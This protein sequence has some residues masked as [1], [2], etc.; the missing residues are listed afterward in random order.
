MPCGHLGADNQQVMRCLPLA[1]R[2]LSM[3]E[4]VGVDGLALGEKCS[5]RG[6]MIDPKV[7]PPSW[8][9]GI[10]KGG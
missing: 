5:R 7:V 4:D 10:G 8:G 3:S 9:S 6:V 1:L 2:D